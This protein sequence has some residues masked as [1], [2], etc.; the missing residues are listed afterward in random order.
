MLADN[1]N[2]DRSIVHAIT[3]R[4]LGIRHPRTRAYWPQTNGKAERFVATMLG[5]W[6]HAAEYRDSH[7]RTRALDGWL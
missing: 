5:G 2:G 1:G 7:E 6:A 4:T 3:C